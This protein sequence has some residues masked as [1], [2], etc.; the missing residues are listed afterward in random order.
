MFETKH[1]G[2]LISDIILNFIHRNCFIA[3]KLNAYIQLLEKIMVNSDQCKCYSRQGKQDK[4]DYICV[5]LQLFCFKRGY[6]EQFEKCTRSYC[7]APANE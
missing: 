6:Q 4:D 7:I 5:G 3:G 2:F 1:H